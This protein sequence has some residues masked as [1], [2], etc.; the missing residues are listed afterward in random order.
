MVQVGHACLEA[1]RRFPFP[2]GTHL[3]VLA[4]GDRSQ[5][6]DALWQLDRQHISYALF[7]EPDDGMGYT[8]ACTQC[9]TARRVL[10]RYPLWTT[11]R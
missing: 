5:L 3:V 11:P 9:V 4:V 2:D 6:L 8:A 10:R 1:G 7:D